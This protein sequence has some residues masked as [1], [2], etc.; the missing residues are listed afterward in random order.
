MSFWRA[1]GTIGAV[2]LVLTALSI[3]WV[4]LQGRTQIYTVA[5]TILSLIA[6]ALA[7]YLVSPARSIRL[8]AL[9]AATALFIGLGWGEL[10]IRL[11]VVPPSAGQSAS[12]L[13]GM[14][15]TNPGLL[16]GTLALLLIIAAL[17]GLLGAWL[18]HRLTGRARLHDTADAS[19]RRS[20]GWR[21]RVLVS[22]GL[23]AVLGLLLTSV[24]LAVGWS[25]ARDPPTAAETWMRFVVTHQYRGAYNLSSPT[26]RDQFGS[27]DELQRW[28]ASHPDQ[29]P[30]T[31]TRA[32]A[33][34]AG[35]ETVVRGTAT[36]ADGHTGDVEIDVTFVHNVWRVDR[37]IFTLQP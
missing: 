7:G 14:W 31:W 17:S 24:V 35:P 5:I 29:Q 36:F 1:I 9:A 15:E 26:L 21:R 30:T 19:G 16:M 10:A 20:W 3:V 28:F 23:L 8:G 22:I 37:F 12:G 13:L 33:T 25:E 27:A 6:V 2:E 18:R 34:D 11:R 4:D 32:A